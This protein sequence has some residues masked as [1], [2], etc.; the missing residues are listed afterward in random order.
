V[1]GEKEVAKRK[2]LIV[3]DEQ[4]IRWSLEQGLRSAGYETRQAASGEEALSIMQ[5]LRPDVVLLDLSMPGENGFHVM[6]RAASSGLAPLFIVLTGE[7]GIATATKAI[8]NGAVDY[9]CKP[10]EIDDVALRIE[11]ALEEARI[12]KIARP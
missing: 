12:E 10:F 8:K 9:I 3:D 2:V 6:E 5:G 4:L 7:A 11:T 1:T